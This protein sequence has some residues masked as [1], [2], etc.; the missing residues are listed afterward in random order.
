MGLDL[1][2]VAFR[3]EQAFGI[4]MDAEDFESLVH[5]R[6]IVVGDLYGLILRKI[7]FRDTVRTNI[8]LNFIVWEELREHLSKA[9]GIAKG[10][11]LLKTLLEDVFPRNTRRV[12]WEGMRSTSPYHIASLD[13]PRAIQPI[14]LSLAA[15]M[16][17]VEQ[18]Q[19]WRIPGALFLWPILG[20]VG[21]WMFAESYTKVMFFFAAWRTRFPRGMKTVK[22]LMRS[23]LTN[24]S[25]KIIADKQS[26][27]IGEIEIPIDDRS[28]A[29]WYQIQEIL[30]DALGVKIEKVNLESR[31]GADLGA[32]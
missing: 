31:L 2:D 11:I 23:I 10:E 22:D 9:S 3:V 5:N 4:K 8:P 18:F 15:A 21:L 24:N 6:D 25:E 12:A 30:S 26:G 27:V 16:V 14:G 20:I 32:E 29:V 17:L 1:L 19:I 13:Y 28:I 7:Q